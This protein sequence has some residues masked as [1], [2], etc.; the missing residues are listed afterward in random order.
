MK[1]TIKTAKTVEEAIELALAE[2]G[3]K[4]DEVTV[5]V[6]EEPSKG[7][8]GLIG[9]KEAKVNVIADK[10]PAT[11]AE[12]FLTK[13]IEKMGIVAKPVINR[14]NEN[15]YID[16]QGDNKEDMGL[17]IGKRG[18]TLDSIQYLTS[19]VVNAN[20]TDYMKVL[21]DTE[22]YREK[23]KQ[24]LEELASKMAERVKKSGKNIKLEP[25]NPYERRIIH[26]ALQEDSSVKT[27]S[28]G[29]G[30]FRRVMIELK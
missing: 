15:L 14:E 1:S 3:V 26:S 28:V 23:R 6:L 11:I 24:T 8:L 4:K 9:N 17:I 5:S 30:E 16:L 10:D 25:M 27:H 20:R 21:L 19:I 12:D 2:L 29:E 7:F 13:M 22:D 18:K